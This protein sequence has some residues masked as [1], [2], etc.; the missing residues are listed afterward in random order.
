MEDYSTYC[1]DCKMNTNITYDHTSGDTICLE[2]GLV[3][4]AHSIDESSEWRNF[5]VDCNSAADNDPNRVGFASNPLLDHNHLSTGISK[6]P[7][8]TKDGLG[9]SSSVVY[10]YQN[11]GGSNQDQVLIKGFET[12]GVMCDRLNLVTTV[13]DRANEIYKTVED[14]KTIKGRKNQDAILAACLHIACQEEH[15]PRTLKEFVSVANGATIKE[16][17]KARM[18][19]EKDFKQDMGENVEVVESVHATDFVSRFCSHLDLKFQTIKAAKE[20]VSKSEQLDIR[21][22]P[23]TV[24]AAV[25]YMLTQLSSEDKRPLEEIAGATGVAVTTIRN[26]YKDVYPYASRLVPN[27]YAQEK[28]LK[29]L[30]AA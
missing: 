29:Y 13:K 16:I 20:A 24:A 11:R 5:A 26:A 9:F 12:I 23:T 18:K 1:F 2:C 8:S 7:N 14:R 15:K 19:I 6:A 22:N 10:R 4:E 17:R 25:I 21:R 30:T 28:D 3:L 27:Y